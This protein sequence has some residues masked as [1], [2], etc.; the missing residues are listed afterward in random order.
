MKLYECAICGQ[1][2]D[3]S[4]VCKKCRDNY[5]LALQWVKDLIEREKQWRN[6]QRRDDRHNAVVFS[7]YMVYQ[8][9]DAYDGWDV[10]DGE[11]EGLRGDAFLNAMGAS[12][13]Y[14]QENDWLGWDEEWTEYALYE[15]A[16]AANLTQGE[17]NALRVYLFP[18]HSLAIDSDE[19]AIILSQI[20]GKTVSNDAFRRRKSDA[21][22]KFKQLGERLREIAP[23]DR[24]QR[25]TDSDKF[26]HHVLFLLY[27]LLREFGSLL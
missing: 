25:V 10:L 12:D 13:S 22:K 4:L 2:V 9:G 24:V 7:D 18:P 26:S 21:F 16:E 15:V 19:A 8:D 6:I 23:A 20:E 1:S 5:D 3:R 14:F 27:E 11:V 17:L